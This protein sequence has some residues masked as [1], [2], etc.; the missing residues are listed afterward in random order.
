MVVLVV[1]TG[2]ASS[3]SVRKCVVVASASGCGA[4]E[5]RELEGDAY[6]QLNPTRQPPGLVG[7]DG[8]VGA[9]GPAAVCRALAS[10]EL[11]PVGDID[12]CAAVDSLMEVSKKV[13]LG[14][15]AALAHVEAMLAGVDGVALDAQGAGGGGHASGFLLGARPTLADVFLAVDVQGL[16][17]KG[18]VSEAL[19][20]W[21]ARVAAAVPALGEIKAA[22]PGGAGGG[23]SA[24]MSAE[25]KAA[26]KEA[27]KAEKARLKAEKEAKQAA[28]AAARGQKQAAA[29]APTGLVYPADGS[30]LESPFGELGVV[31]SQV[32]SGRVYTSLEELPNKVG[33]AVWIRARVQRTR[34]K[35][36]TAFIVMRQRFETAQGC[37]F[38]GENGVTKDMVRFAGQ[39]TTESVVDFE[40]EVAA[41]TVDGCSVS[42]V[43]LKIRHIYVVSKAGGNPPFL[44]EDAMRPEPVAVE[45]AGFQSADGDPMATVGLP[46]RLNHRFLDLRTPANLGIFRVHSQVG[47]LF[48]EFLCAED[49]TEIHTPKLISTASEGGSNVF[50]L[51]YFDRKAYLAQSPQLYKQMAI[52]GDFERVFEVAPVFRAENSNTHRH[53]TEFTGL[54]LEM[55]ISEH[56]HEILDLLDRLMVHIF[57]GIEARCTRELKA[58][59]EQHG[60]SFPSYNKDGPNLR[61]KYQ[62]GIAL[63]RGA[64]IEIGDLDDIDTTN[65]KLLGR[66]VKEKYGTDFYILTGF[67]AWLRPF[68]T[69][70]DPENPDY[71][72]SFDMF[73][74]GEEICSGAQRVHDATLLAAQVEAKGVPV[75][76]IQDYVDAFKLGA[77]PH[78]GAGLGLD[79][80]VM[81]YLGLHNI[82][83]SCLFPRDPARLAP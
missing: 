51:G 69:M 39:L 8:A 74:R 11:Y 46:L 49:F 4:V 77:P 67:P 56:Y 27:K 70:P 63:L 73:I 55:I 17:S 6:V 15:K 76:Q 60:F 9:A 71:S 3:A 66:L 58:F 30:H 83:R 37:M 65:E 18:G 31:Q 62:E 54:D 19:S 38:A 28:T 59:G 20:G 5:V 41:S 33:Q 72:N 68:Y 79:R 23:G 22:V 81:Y 29:E 7:E 53:L 2:S 26:A 25:E 12:A 57:N 24:A 40:G 64:G 34:A 36:A 80:V 82:R 78:G 10:A 50:A 14:D 48:R 1:P 61:I 44:F 16:L 43:E 32:R 45:G 13:A 35:G 21:L 52:C 75:D 47:C 42:N